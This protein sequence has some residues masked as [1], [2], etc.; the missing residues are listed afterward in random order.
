MGRPGA[1]VSG[2][3]RDEGGRLGAAMTDGDGAK[4][5]FD[6]KG[7]A[8]GGGVGC[9]GV[10]CGGVGRGGVGRGGVGRGGVGRGGVGRRGQREVMSAVRA[11]AA[12]RTRLD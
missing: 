11:G 3:A 5:A 6:V 1:W 2:D 10:G 7:T 4:A 8:R 12:K 9:G